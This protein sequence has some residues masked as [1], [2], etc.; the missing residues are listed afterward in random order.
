[1]IIDFDDKY[2]FKII[3][4]NGVTNDLPYWEFTPRHKLIAFH[5]D[6]SWSCL[7]SN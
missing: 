5:E 3:P 4:E 1:M 2:E 7:K 6:W